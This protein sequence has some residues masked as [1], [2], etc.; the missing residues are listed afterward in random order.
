MDRR[1]PGQSATPMLQAIAEGLRYVAKHPGIGPLLA[2]HATMAVTARPYVELLPGFADAIFNR[3]AGGLATLSS[4][5]GLGAIVAGLF[6]AQRSSQEGLPRT[7]MLAAL[8]IALSALGLAVSPT[9][10]TAVMAVTTGGFGMVVAGVGTQTLMQTSVDDAVRGRVLSLFGLVF[11][12]GPA[13]GALI[14]GVASEQVGLRWPLA[15][16][17]LMGAAAFAYIWRHRQTVSR[18]LQA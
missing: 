15:I 2:L 4:A 9:F 6:L 17:A 1:K 12:S 14:M 8:L 11:R 3:G 7:A 13:I 18:A 16:G 5:V 10:W